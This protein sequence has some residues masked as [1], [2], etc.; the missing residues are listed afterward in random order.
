MG[1]VPKDTDTLW[2]W[3]ASLWTP[4]VRFIKVKATGL[5]QEAAEMHTGLHLADC[6]LA[7]D[8]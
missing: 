4:P 2:L 3:E 6:S 1:R 5:F 7:L 8:V